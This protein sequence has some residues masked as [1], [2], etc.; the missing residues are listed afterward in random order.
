MFVSKVD[1]ATSAPGAGSCSAF[2]SCRLSP[3]VLLENWCPDAYVEFPYAEQGAQRK[4]DRNA[5]VLLESR[6]SV[7]TV[8]DPLGPFYNPGVITVL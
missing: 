5:G 6:I 3:L 7:K 8:G 1:D 2:Q 4:L